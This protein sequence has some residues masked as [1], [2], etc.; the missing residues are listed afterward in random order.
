M[1]TLSDAIDDFEKEMQCGEIPLATPQATRKAEVARIA[2]AIYIRFQ[3]EPGFAGDPKLIA[4]VAFRNA[5]EFVAYKES[6]K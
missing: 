2:E 1:K 4:L 3:T 6:I 5:E